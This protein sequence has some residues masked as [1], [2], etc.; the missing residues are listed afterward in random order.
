MKRLVAVLG[1]AA[2]LTVPTVAVAQYGNPSGGPSMGS[3][4]LGGSSMGGSMPSMGNSMPSGGS[5]MDG[6]PAMAMGQDSVTIAN[7]SFQPGTIS[8]PAGTT[9][10]WQNADAVAHTVTSDSGA[11]DSGQIPPGGS[12]STTF[13]Q[14]G[15]YTYHCQ[16][17]PSMTGSVMVT[18]S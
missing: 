12:F 14:P 4:P 13:S 8:V 1:L 15:L 6:A 9:V 18:S 16:I 5:S 17:H 10:T 2:A 7:F 3:Y 11:F